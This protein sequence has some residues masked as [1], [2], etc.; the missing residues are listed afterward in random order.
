MNV[1]NES[2]ITITTGAVSERPIPDW[3]VINSYATGHHGMARGL[4]LD[5]A[6]IRVNTVSPGAVDTELWDHLPA[7]KRSS[8]FEGMKAGTTTGK[9]AKP[10]D[11][12]ESFLYLMKDHNISG[13]VISTNGGHLL[14]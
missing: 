1:S 5:L 2:S 4:A 12:A 8:L 7:D 9:V 14:K 3:A 13:S 10:E 6:P 11:I